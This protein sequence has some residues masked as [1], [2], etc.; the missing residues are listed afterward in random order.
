MKVWDAR[1]GTPILKLRAHTAPFWSLAFSPDGT[2][3]LTGRADGAATVWDVRSGMALF[4]LKGHTGAV[5]SVAFSPDGTRIVTGSATPH[6]AG[7]LKEW[8]AGTGAP[9][10]N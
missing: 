6:Y 7:E 3:I 8:D 1:T 2:R 10:S 9:S 5:S 4:E